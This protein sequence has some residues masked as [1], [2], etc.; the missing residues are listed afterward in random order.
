MP[1]ECVVVITAI[2]HFAMTEIIRSSNLKSKFLSAKHQ[3][4]LLF[5]LSI[6]FVQR[7]NVVSFEDECMCGV[8][9]KIK[10]ENVCL[11]ACKILISNFVKK[12]NGC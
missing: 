12:L 2:V 6:V 9:L 1:S 4:S 11:I 5:K 7:I 10:L 8:T 3:L